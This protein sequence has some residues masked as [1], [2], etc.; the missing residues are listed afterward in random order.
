VTSDDKHPIAAGLIA[1]IAVGLAV[2]LLLGVITLVLSR[3]AGL[4]GDD[5]SETAGTGPSL[6]LPSPVPTH[7]SAGSPVGT[8]TSQVPSSAPPSTKAA[9]AITLQAA[10]PS[11]APMER[12]DLSGVYP[13]GEGAVLQVQRMDEGGKWEDFPVTAA[14]SGQTFSTYV[15][16][17]RSGVQRFRMRDSDTRLVSNVVAVTVR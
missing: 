15:Q 14:V 9:K 13:G 8:A 6:Y 2:G 11:V 12:I 10:A 16:T 4:G 7:S 5:G 17:G 1:L 3:V